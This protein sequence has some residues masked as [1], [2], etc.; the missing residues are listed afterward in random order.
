MNLAWLIIFVVAIIYLQ[1]VFFQKFGFKGLTYNRSFNKQTAFPNEKIEII[2]EITNRKLLPLPWVS[3]EA[4]MSRYLVSVV[5]EEILEEDAFHQTL[6]SLLPY[7]QIKRRHH[8]VVKKRGVYH[9]ASV[10]LTLGDMF[11]F[12]DTYQSH[13][14]TGKLIVYPKLY[15]KNTLPEDVQVFLGEHAVNRWIIDDPFLKIGTRDYQTG[16]ASHKINWKQTA[17]RRDLQVNEH[18]HTREL[19]LTIVLNVDQSD[20]IWLPVNDDALFEESIS[21]VG[22][23]FYQLNQQAAPFRFLTNAVT[24]NNRQPD[25]NDVQLLEQGVGQGHYQQGLTTLSYLIPER[26]HHFKHVL[27]YLIRRSTD[28]TLVILTPVITEVITTRVEALK[29]NGNQVTL[30]LIKAPKEVR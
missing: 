18:D 22:S 12:S 17:K 29:K 4:K 10:A 16:D 3:V 5:N 25:L 20:D 11:G 30:I 9:L 1:S 24:I 14:T 7:Q 6:F 28:E 19:D 23:M 21:I 26:Q 13:E 8:M 2:D 27:D 15:R